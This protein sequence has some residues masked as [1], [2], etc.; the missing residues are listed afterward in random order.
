MPTISNGTTFAVSQALPVTKDQAGF[1]SLTY[2]PIRGV[3]SVGDIGKQHQT[4]PSNTIGDA[5]PYNRRVGLAAAS[6]PME[7]IRIADAG[8]TLLRAA[9]DASVSYSYRLTE[10]DGS[11][12]Y[13]TAAATSRMHGGFASG[14]IADTKMSLEIDSVIVEI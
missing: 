12:M 5:V 13:F 10:L 3:R 1:A 4:A 2:T 7:L 8:Q 6:L 14:G 9:I 11:L